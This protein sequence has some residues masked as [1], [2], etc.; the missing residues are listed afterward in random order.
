VPGLVK[1]NVC[2]RAMTTLVSQRGY[3]A[4]Q[5]GQSPR[6]SPGFH[7]L[8]MTYYVV[9]YERIA[10]RMLAMTLTELEADAGRSSF[11]IAS[12]SLLGTAAGP[13]Q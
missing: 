8:H 10:S 2:V 5:L 3:G 1:L 13:S 4:R 7:L 6:I 12:A 9:G 11:G